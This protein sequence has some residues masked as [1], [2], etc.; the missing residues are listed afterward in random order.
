MA[1]KIPDLPSAR[2]YKE[3]TADF[4]EIQAIR[5]P[6]NYVSQTQISKAIAIGLDELN[7]DGLISEDDTLIDGDEKITGLEDVF[8]ELQNRLEYTSKKYPFDFGKYS[9]KLN[10]NEDLD[11]RVYLFLLLCTR[12]NMLTQKIQ[13]GIDGTLLFEK[14]C[15]H[16]ARNFFG[17]NSE[18]LVFGTANPGNFEAKVKH[19]ISKIGE[20]ESFKNPNNNPPSKNDDSIDVVVWKDFSD[21]R[22]GKLIGFGQCKTG[23]STWRDDKHKLKPSDFCNKWFL[24]SP[25]YPPI[26]LLFICDTLNENYNFYSDQQGFIIFNRFRIL[27]YM[28]ATIED[29]LINDI[30]LWLSGALETLNIRN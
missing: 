16:V 1:Y 15:A 29:S 12:L 10:E 17:T 14:L 6:G 18:S 2:A 27:E 26:S 23:T 30:Q 13:N 19:L 5:N 3:E 4:W 11:Q 25:V 20:G 9:L 7:H 8:I 22:I 24:E 21:K 28:S